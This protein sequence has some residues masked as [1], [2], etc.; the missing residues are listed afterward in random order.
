MYGK[1]LEVVTVTKYFGIT[2]KD[3]INNIVASVNQAQGMLSRN[4]KKKAPHQTKT[5][6]STH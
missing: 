5:I 1:Q 3:D 2:I 4:T 6:L